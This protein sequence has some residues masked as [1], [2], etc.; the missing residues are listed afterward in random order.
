MVFVGFFLFLRVLKFFFVFEDFVIFFV[1]FL[2]LC[3]VFVW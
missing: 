2:I 3:G 1:F